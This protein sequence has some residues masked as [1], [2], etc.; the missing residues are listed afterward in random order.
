MGYF[1]SDNSGEFL[2]QIGLYDRTSLSR[3]M[4]RNDIVKTG[5]ANC[6]L[7]VDSDLN[8]W[9]QPYSTYGSGF[10]LNI[11]GSRDFELDFQQGNSAA[12]GTPSGFTSLGVITSATS[13]TF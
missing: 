11:V 9:V 5:N 3:R 12:L 7:G 4:T 13:V 8:V 10:A 2:L 1:R 6:A